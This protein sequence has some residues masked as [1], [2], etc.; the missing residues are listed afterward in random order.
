MSCTFMYFHAT[1][2][3]AV[4]YTNKGLLSSRVLIITVYT[5][6]VL[7]MYLALFSTPYIY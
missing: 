3:E 5:N 1:F 2:Y 4:S 7:I 6:L